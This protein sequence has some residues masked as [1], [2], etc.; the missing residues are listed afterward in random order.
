MHPYI[1]V[2]LFMLG[3]YVLQ[4]IFSLK[5]IKHFNQSYSRLREQG[6][7]AIGRRPGK[8]QSGTIFMFAVDNQGK[9]LDAMMMQGVTV[10]ARFKE[11]PKYIDEFITELTV[12]HPIVKKE[13]K[14]VRQAVL[15]AKDLY[16][17]VQNNDYHEETPL[18]P[19]SLLKVQ[20]VGYGRHLK[21][22]FKNKS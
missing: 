19:F 6:K 15:D 21:G 16:V 18:S 10:L 11:R 4:T 8:I 20:A 14:L 9:I 2:G 12:N 22:F 13:N 3:A 5:Q 7:V 1:L 17:K